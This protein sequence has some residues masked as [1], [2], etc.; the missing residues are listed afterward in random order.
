MWILK[1]ANAV[2][3]QSVSPGGVAQVVC[4]VTA[5]AE[6]L[7]NASSGLLTQEGNSIIEE[8]TNT[9]TILQYKVFT[10]KIFL[11]GHPQGVYISICIKRRL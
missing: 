11:V 1:A 7:G 8:Y 6:R 10:I 9:C 3:R 4:G 5:G 2:T